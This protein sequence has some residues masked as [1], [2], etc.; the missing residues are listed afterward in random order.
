MKNLIALLFLTLF[1]SAC[2]NIAS[3]GEAKLCD[4]K[5][6]E[7]KTNV[8]AS[9]TENT[10]TVSQLKTT[11]G[12]PDGIYNIDE[13]KEYSY[14]VHTGDKNSAYCGQYRFSVLNNKVV[15]TATYKDYITKP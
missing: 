11:L 14:R 9:I 2:G 15:Q 13:P 1:T 6:A 12:D 10:T 5:F 4:S 7:W 8:S 3:Y